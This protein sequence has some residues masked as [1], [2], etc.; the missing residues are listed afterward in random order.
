MLVTL[1]PIST[2]VK[3]LQYEKRFLPDARNAVRDRDA[4]QAAATPVFTTDYYS[5]FYR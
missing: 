5:I 4:R 2:L 1:F 3:P